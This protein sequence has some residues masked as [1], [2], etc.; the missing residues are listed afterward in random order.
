VVK[1]TP[2]NKLQKSIDVAQQARDAALEQT[3]RELGYMEDEITNPV[4]FD[5]LDALTI[6]QIKQKVNTT[7][8]TKEQVETLYETEV[9]GKSRKGVLTYLQ[10]LLK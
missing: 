3:L 4:W 8:L 1:V 2:Q 9:Q 6:V 10:G 7:D 5:E